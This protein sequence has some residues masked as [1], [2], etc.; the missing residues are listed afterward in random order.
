MNDSL[1]E[2]GMVATSDPSARLVDYE[3]ERCERCGATR[4]LEWMIAGGRMCKKCMN[5]GYQIIRDLVIKDAAKRGVMI[6]PAIMEILS[7]V[8]VEI[9]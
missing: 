9:E 4:Q 8:K 5:D 3:P 2:N 7:Y 6:D 1:I